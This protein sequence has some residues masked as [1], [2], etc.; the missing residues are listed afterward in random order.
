MIQITFHPD[1]TAE[2]I[3]DQSYPAAKL[4]QGRARTTRASHVEPA[5]FWLRWAF[6]LAR[7]CGLTAWTRLWACAWRI[8]VIGGPTLPGVYQDRAEAIRA[9]I[10][11]LE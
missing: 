5:A 9:E 8:R 6:H 7:K 3:G 1:G 10:A 4:V 11:W 2:Y